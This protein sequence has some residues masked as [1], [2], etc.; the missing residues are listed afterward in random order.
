[1]GDGDRKEEDHSSGKIHSES[2]LFSLSLDEK[3]DR[4]AKHTG[5]EKERNNRNPSFLPLSS[6]TILIT[7]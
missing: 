1:M 3:M 2:Y 6:F 5:P 7:M 4:R